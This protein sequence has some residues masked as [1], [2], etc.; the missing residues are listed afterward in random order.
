MSTLS[1]ST[2]FD[3]TPGIARALNLRPRDVGAVIT[4]L[5]DGNTVPFVARYRK[6]ATGGL[7]EVAIEAIEVAVKA[8]RVLEDRRE[9]VLKAIREQGKLDGALERLIRE[10]GDKQTLEDLYLPFKKKRKT[11]ASVARERGLAPLAERVLAQ[12]RDGHPGREARRFLGADVPDV[13]AA[14]AGA[15]DIVAASLAETASIRSAVRAFTVRHGGIRSAA[16]KKAVAGKRT[17]FEDYYDFG[18]GVSRIPSHRYLAMCRGEE[19]G[20]LR[21]SVD[22]D[23]E[24]MVSHIERLA[25]LRRGSPWAAELHAAA[26]DSYKRLLGPSIANEIR[27]LV[28]ARAEA[29]AV[30]VFATNLENLLLSAPYGRQRVVGIDPG[31]RSGCKCAALSETGRFLAHTTV[32]PH[33]AGRDKQAPGRA[34]VD[35]VRHHRAEAVA[36]GNGTA[37]RETLDFARQVLGEAGLEVLVVSVN[38]AGA[39]IYS[40]SA[41]AR[42]EFPELD[43]TVRGAI[44]IGRRLQDPLAELVKVDPQSLGVG[45]Y[46]HDVTQSLLTDRLARVVERCVNR[47]GAQLDTA[48]AALLQYVAGIGPVTARRIVER[49]D[50]EGAFTARR[51]LL[52]VKGLGPKAFEQAAGFLRIRGAANP[53]DDS[54]VHPERYDLVRR[55]AR[56]LGVPV[57]RLVGDAGLA[58]R[59]DAGRY[60]EVGALTLADIL[61]EL[62]KPG[63]DPRESFEPPR[64]RDDVQSVSDLEVGMVLEG[65]VTNV[66]AFGAFVDIGV[67]QDGLVH[68]SKLADSFVRDPHAV[69]AVGQRLTV[70]VMEVD[71]DRQRISLSVR[72]V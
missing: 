52:D 43:L 60:A 21:V 17:P 4:M 69:V 27:G 45:Q 63:L 54:A 44:S 30:D 67:H 16:V 65:V 37:G 62:A 59:I 2:G 72:D 61:Q 55:M 64:F 35:F 41:T 42:E 50:S 19:E 5:A 33:T 14:L 58:R 11:R 56:E 9:A 3:P 6:E 34:L 39:S 15:R 71:L 47:V 38:E 7:D 1:T 57:S 53:L 49:R 40:A 66:A 23:G 28:R 10:A 51:Q 48:S 13:D 8:A 70:R 26:A 22:I 68:V 46:Q 24:R 25:G 31:F 12:P 36:V 18:E 32:Y 29:E 20:M